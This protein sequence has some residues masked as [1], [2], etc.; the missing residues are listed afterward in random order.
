MENLFSI[1]FLLCPLN[2]N[3]TNL[4][5]RCVDV[6][7]LAVNLVLP[8]IEGKADKKETIKIGMTNI[9]DLVLALVLQK[10]IMSL[11]KRSMMSLTTRGI[12]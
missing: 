12:N 2:T 7:I 1:I 10:N 6:G 5:K 4:R 9:N 11:L 8:L 3:T